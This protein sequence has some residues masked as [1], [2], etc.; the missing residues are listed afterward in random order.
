MQSAIAAQ[1]VLND[2]KRDFGAERPEI[3]AERPVHYLQRVP[4]EVAAHVDHKVAG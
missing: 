4:P 3:C 2:Q 1:Q